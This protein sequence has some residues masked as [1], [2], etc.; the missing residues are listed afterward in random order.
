MLSEIS[1]NREDKNKPLL[2]CTGEV[3]YYLQL[4]IGARNVDPD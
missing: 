1:Q 2:Y 3:V 4:T